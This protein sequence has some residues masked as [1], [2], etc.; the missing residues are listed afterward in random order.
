MIK[1]KNIWYFGDTLLTELVYTF[2]PM[3]L[4]SPQYIKCT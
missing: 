1:D 2:I 4:Q 3:Y